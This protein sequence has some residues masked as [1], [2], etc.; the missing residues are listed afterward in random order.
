MGAPWWEL[1]GDEFDIVCDEQ[2]NASLMQLLDIILGI[3]KFTDDEF[4]NNSNFI[5]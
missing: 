4:I 3:L 5:Y 2:L 1:H